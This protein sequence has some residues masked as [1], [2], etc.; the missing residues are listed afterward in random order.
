MYLT[1]GSSSASGQGADTFDAMTDTKQRRSGL[2]PTLVGI[3]LVVVGIGLGVT[4]E[5]G[6]SVVP[7]MFGLLLGAAGVVVLVARL[8]VWAVRR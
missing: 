5:P 4:A 8:I 7:I 1:H 3:G 2:V 6:G